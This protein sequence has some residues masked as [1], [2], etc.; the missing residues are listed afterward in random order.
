MSR[1]SELYSDQINDDIFGFI[2]KKLS[3]KK[4]IINLVMKYAKESFIEIGSGTGILCVHFAN[5]GLDV[6]GID[7]DKD[8]LDISL[9]VKKAYAKSDKVKFY[10]QD[11]FEITTKKKYD[12]IF[13][14]GVLE[15]YSNEEIIK[16]IELQ[17]EIAETVIICI[18]TKFFS[19]RTA[20]YGNERYLALSD[21]R[22]LIKDAGS[23][24]VEESYYEYFTNFQ[25]IYRVDKWM[26][27]K[28]FHIFVCQKNK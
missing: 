16:A 19:T 22:K 14:N 15:H 3:N 6:V 13:S 28:P 18:P 4:N 9:E 10:Y 23:N 26:K 20:M 7:N 12:V 24:I 25:K 8:M 17:H 27:P 21:W 1:W 2:E 5:L 11:L